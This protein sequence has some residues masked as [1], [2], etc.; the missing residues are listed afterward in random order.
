MGNI[1]LAV[2]EPGLS[3][4]CLPNCGKGPVAAEDKVRLEASPLR[5]VGPE[6]GKNSQRLKGLLINEHMSFWRIYNTLPYETLLC[7]NPHALE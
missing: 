1:S 4:K 7:T 2:V 5:G 3:H 6:Q